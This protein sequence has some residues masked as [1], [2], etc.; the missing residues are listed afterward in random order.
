[1]ATVSE[2]GNGALAELTVLDLSHY[3]AGAYCGKLLAAFGAEVIKIEA[4]GVGDGA[5]QVGPF[6]DRSPDPEASAL[7]L[8][9]N[10]GKKGLT[11]DLASEGGSA[12]LKELVTQ[13]DVLI[14][15]FAPGVME[16]MGLD[17]ATLSAINPRLVMASIS[18]FGQSG[19]YREYRADTMV[20]MALSGQM[21]VNGDPDREPLSS[22]GYQPS[23][24]SALYAYSGIMA[25]LI[26]RDR[27]DKGQYLDVSI[28]EAMVSEHQFTLNGFTA[29]GKI[30]MRSG[31]RYGSVHPSTI[32]PCKADD[33]GKPG[34]VS[35]GISDPT[36][37][38]L[39]LQLLDMS[40]LLDDPRFA[41]PQMCAVNY[42]EFDALI[43]TWF[44]DH[45]AEEIVNALQDNRIPAAFVNEVSDVLDDPQY[46]FRGFWKEID[47]PV[48]GNH[49]YAGLPYHLSE[50]PPVYER[51]NLLGEH[52]NEVL[53][54]KLGYDSD[55]LGQLREGGVI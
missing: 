53:A 3:V 12:I 13:T 25:A 32:L 2:L 17:Y 18:N 28:Q 41:N 26:A 46:E 5:R 44:M 4:P 55:R 49:R 1:M 48:A 42:R 40:E 29:S 51:A 43:S 31:N 38:V 47:H 14:E 37:Y 8:Y 50:A 20:E 19:P 34:L 35:L 7:Y 23:Y 22:S 6:P 21:Y 33:N 45:T 30:R 36:Q 27:D 9:L 52:T 39:F 10:T 54:E 11:L 16:S 15:N 24:Q